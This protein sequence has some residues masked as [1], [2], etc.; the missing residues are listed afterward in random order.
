MKKSA[1][2]LVLV[3]SVCTA[4]ANSHKNEFPNCCR[5][6]AIH[7]LWFMQMSCLL[8]KTMMVIPNIVK[9]SVSGFS[10]GK[11]EAGRNKRGLCIARDE[12]KSCYCVF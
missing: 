2:R 10:L 4:H 11:L 9:S 7:P 12:S 5:P 1:T 6:T 8:K 3:E